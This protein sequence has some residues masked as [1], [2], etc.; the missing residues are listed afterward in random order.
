MRGGLGR[1]VNGCGE[2]GLRHHVVG[3]KLVEGEQ[4]RP[5][6]VTGLEVVPTPR[7]ERH[8][9]VTETAAVKW[10]V[11]RCRTRS[12]HQFCQGWLRGSG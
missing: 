12:P 5:R 8:V 11:M 4:R 10:R 9:G 2:V 7:R 3:G 6:R 1:N